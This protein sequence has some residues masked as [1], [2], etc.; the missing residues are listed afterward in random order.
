MQ[1]KIYYAHYREIDNTLQT[2]KEHLEGTA[3]LSANYCSKIGLPLI[4]ELLGLLH[5]IGKYSTAFQNYFLSGIGKITPEMDGYVRADS[6]KGKIDYATSGG[7][8]I[9]ENYCNTPVQQIVSQFISLCL[10]SH[11]GGLIDCL[12]Y[13]F[14]N[15]GTKS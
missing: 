11:H 3:K 6:L 10:I 1:S 14:I 15:N 5:D 7:Q 12:V 8:F 4:G 9:W 2:V 13:V